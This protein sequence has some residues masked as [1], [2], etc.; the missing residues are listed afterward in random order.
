MST[1]APPVAAACSCAGCLA[2][3]KPFTIE[4]LRAWAGEF[5]LDNDEPWILDPYQER[6]ACDLF[7]GFPICWLVVPEEN[8]KTTFVAGLSLYII[9]HKPSAYVPVAASSRDQAEWIYRQAEGFVSRAD[10]LA[11]GKHDAG[12][13][14]L[15]GYRR[16]RFDAMNSR[17]QVFAA[18][19]RSGDGIIPGGIA[20][21]DELHR[22]RDL[23]LYRTWLG[24]LRKRSA[25]L[26]VISTA[27]E[28]AS[29]FEEERDRLRREAT[30]VNYEG[31][32]YTRAE[33]FLGEK[34]LAVLHD[35]AIPEDG[36]IEDLELVKEANPFSGVTLTSLREK[37]QMTSSVQHWERFTC[38]RPTRDERSAIQEREWA[39]RKS[40]EEIPEG[41]PIWLGLDVAW[42]WDTT[43][44]VPLWWRD[45]EFRLLGPAHILVPPR[46]GSSLSPERVQEMLI[47]IHERNPLHTVVMDPTRADQLALWISDAFGSTVIEHSQGN[48][49]AALDYERIMEALREGWLW[50]AGDLG[51]TRHA[52]NAITRL[53]PAGGARFARP[54][55]TRQGGDQ[56]AR[57]IDALDAASMVH[58]AAVAL[59][60]VPAA[61]PLIAWV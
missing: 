38:N 50:H 37:R 1:A 14:C 44:A 10:R 52:L 36:D 60:N 35:Y 11:I 24:K 30:S 58:S 8:G 27:G 2:G 43:A 49:Q 40:D 54:S 6:F 3:F 16:I 34:R 13:R 26:V 47:R 59:L 21:L 17:I 61:T 39:L 20:V 33:H 48:A 9:E 15:E 46:D 32:C 51:L 4:H 25:Q 53:L 7:A 5:T 28:V 12:F 56:E 55:Q 18:D 57:V 23:A 41:E 19:D 22:H 42:K 45:D 31:R 29:E